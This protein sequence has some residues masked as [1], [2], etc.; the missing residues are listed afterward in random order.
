MQN[1]AWDK[2]GISILGMTVLVGVSLLGQMS[3]S[4]ASG[5]VG[6]IGL[7][8]GSHAIGVHLSNMSE[9]GMYG[10]YGSGYDPSSQYGQ[11]N[12]LNQNVPPGGGT[13]I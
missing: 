2:L 10:G 12:Q 6:I 7:Y 3:P 5:V 8:F 9:G 11:Q 13:A 4:L 1:I